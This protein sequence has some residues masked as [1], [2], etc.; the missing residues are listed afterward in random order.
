VWVV[1]PAALMKPFHPQRL[2]ARTRNAL[3]LGHVLVRQWQISGF[4]VSLYR[5]RPS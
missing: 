3:D 1:T 2:P 5:R 4:A